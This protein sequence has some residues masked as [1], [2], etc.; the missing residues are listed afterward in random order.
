MA[1]SLFHIDQD[2]VIQGGSPPG[3]GFRDVGGAIDVHV[4]FS[5]DLSAQFALRLRSVNEQHSLLPG[6]TGDGSGE[7]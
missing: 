2:E 5:H 7:R 4:K 1:L 6:C 3:T